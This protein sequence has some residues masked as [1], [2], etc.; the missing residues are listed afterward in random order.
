[1]WTGHMI[2]SAIMAAYS[3]N[4]KATPRWPLH[5]HKAGSGLTATL[6]PTSF[7]VTVAV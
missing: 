1:M 4:M 7:A 5:L 6:L 3:A 2:A